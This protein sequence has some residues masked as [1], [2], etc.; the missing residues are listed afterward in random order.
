MNVMY[1][2]QEIRYDGIYVYVH[3]ITPHVIYLYRNPDASVD[4]ETVRGRR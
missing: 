1:V 4:R 2:W 3:T